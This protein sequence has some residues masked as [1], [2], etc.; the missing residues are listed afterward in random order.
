ML[1]AKRNAT[2][3]L[4]CGDST[5]G[6]EAANEIKEATKNK[7]AYFMKLDLGD[8]SS[9]S[10]F[11]KEFKSKFKRLD[12][13]VHNGGVF[14]E[15]Y[16]VNKHGF[17][18]TFAVNYFGPV[19]LTSLLLDV[20]EASKPSRIIYTSSKFHVRAK[21]DWDDLQSEKTKIALVSIYSTSK[22]AG[23]LYFK[24]LNRITEP[25][26]VKIVSVHPGVVRSQMNSSFSGA[27]RRLIYWTLYPFWWYCTKNLEQG[28]SADNTL[29]LF[30]RS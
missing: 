15:E 12:I 2:L 28:R 6:I 9:I 16:K 19:Y 10:E 4:A 1:L 21:I 14:N 13:L 23:M 18:D 24:E 20:L 26:G 29:Y 30:I 3:I 25:K 8:L 22:L 17:E 11:V 7:E 5:K 27:I